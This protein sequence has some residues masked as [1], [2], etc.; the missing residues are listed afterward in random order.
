MTKVRQAHLATMHQPCARLVSSSTNQS[1]GGGPEG[2]EHAPSSPRVQSGTFILSKL[3]HSLK[4]K[5]KVTQS[6]LILCDSM[7][8]IVHGIFQA[9]ILEWVAFPFSRGSS[10]PRDQTQVSRI[11]GR[12]FTSWASGKPK[13]TG[14][15]SPSLFQQ[16]FLT[17]ELNWGLL[18][19]RQIL[20][21]K[22]S[23]EGSSTLERGLVNFFLPVANSQVDWVLNKGVFV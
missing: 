1:S 19:C 17:Q 18:Q 23:C 8:C 13:N 16:I 5:V 2:R 11:T 7:D 14:V 15:G 10:Q 20:Y 12:F 9:R 22:L 3:I 6:C 21:I 4:V